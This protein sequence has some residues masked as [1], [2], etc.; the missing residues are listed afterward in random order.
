[1]ARLAA[2]NR[3]DEDIRTLQKNQHELEKCNPDNTQLEV[4]LINRFHMNLSKGDRQPYC[5]HKPRA[6]V[7]SASP[8][9]KPHIR[10]Y[11]G[12]KGVYHEIPDGAS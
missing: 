12:R 2:R 8:Y 5:Y 3:T 4:D 6:G 9:E 11:R 1:M 10:K 7:F